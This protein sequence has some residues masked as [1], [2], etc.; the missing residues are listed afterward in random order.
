MDRLVMALVMLVFAGLLGFVAAMLLLQFKK[1]ND[2][3]KRE[4]EMTANTMGHVVELV[5]VRRRNSTFRWR[6]QYPV[7]AY[8]VNGE[9]YRFHIDFAEHWRGKYQVGDEYQVDYVPTEPQVCLVKD[10]YKKMKSSRT[11]SG[12]VGAI[13]ALMTINML[14]GILNVLIFG[15]AALL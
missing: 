10:F 8:R 6:T 4:K 3:L 1:L 11:G 12:I 13:L 5:T 14:W 2:L 7:I 15:T 9:E